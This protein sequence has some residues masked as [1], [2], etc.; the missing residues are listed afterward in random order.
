MSARARVPGAISTLDLFPLDR[1]Q[2]CCFIGGHKRDFEEDNT[3]FGDFYRSPLVFFSSVPLSLS[4]FLCLAFAA[5]DFFIP[6]SMHELREWLDEKLAQ[7]WLKFWDWCP[8]RARHQRLSSSFELKARKI[9]SSMNLVAQLYAMCG[10]LCW[11][12]S[13]ESIHEADAT[14]YTHCDKRTRSRAPE[15][16]LSF[17]SEVIS[18]RWPDHLPR[19][20]CR[21]PLGDT[22]DV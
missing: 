7:G 18:R 1:S 17:T 22:R 15:N 12:M 6:C 2:P 16:P 13:N 11:C 5:F 14:I 4:L 21:H 19:E 8:R 3:S 10:F 9:L 20:R